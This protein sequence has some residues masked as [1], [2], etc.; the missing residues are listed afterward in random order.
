MSGR[1]AAVADD[2]KT[3]LVK[4]RQI[5]GRRPRCIVAAGGPRIQESKGQEAMSST[6]E[7]A[8]T[9]G[10]KHRRDCSTTTDQPACARRAKTTGA[11]HADRQ[12]GGVQPISR[13][14]APGR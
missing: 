14:G 10:S 1:L 12:A 7:T 2:Q 11:D 3:L 13:V 5:A 6:Y 9:L 4:A 8:E